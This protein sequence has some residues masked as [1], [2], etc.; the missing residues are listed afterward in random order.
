MN[1]W[2]IWVGLGIGAYLLGGVPF[3]L[4]IAKSKG[5]DLFKVGSGNIG[6]TNV[7]RALGPKW[8][9]FVFLLDL[10]KGLVPSAVARQCVPGGPQVGWAMI[11]LC[12]M[13][14]HS[15]SPWIRFKGGK[16]VATLMG[17]ILGASPWVS[18]SSF[19]IFVL[20]V[21]GCRIVSIASIVAILSSMAWA[22][23]YHDSKPM[24]F[25]YGAALLL[26][27]YRHRANFSRLLKGEEP[28]MSFRKSEVVEN[29]PS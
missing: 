27:L 21:A 17:A 3:G 9:L 15:A 29:E 5:I 18:L 10:G 19:G 4:L 26:A 1:P 22:Y 20:V 14:G 28:K 25:V 16:G 8:G 23:F 7:W 6:A 24:Y 11:G 12:A 13:V 2:I